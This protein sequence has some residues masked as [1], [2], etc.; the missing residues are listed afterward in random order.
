M[1]DAVRNNPRIVQIF[2]GLITLPFAFWGI[3]SYIGNPGTGAGSDLASVG[4]V[5]ITYP[6]FELAVRERQEQ[7]RQSLGDAF[8][9]DMMNSPQIRLSILN[10]MIDQQLLMLDAAN[11]RLVTSD[12]ALRSLIAGI[13]VFQ[14]NGAFSQARYE[15][16]LRAQGNSP[17]RFEARVREELSLRQLLGT[18]DDAA[19][20]SATQTEAIVRIQVEERKFNEFRIAAAPFTKNLK[21]DPEVMRKFYD[22]NISRFEVPEQV[23]AEY[24]ALSLDDLMSRVMVSDA[25]IR[26]WYDDHLD[27]Y[28]QPEERRASH[29]LIIPDEADR[30]K[31]KAQAEELLKDARQNPSRFA[32]L[33]QKHS[34]DPGSAEKG[35]DLGFFGRGMMVEPFDDAVF[36]LKKGDI[37]DVVESDFGYHIIRLTDIREAKQRPFSEVRAEIGDELKRQ[38][39]NREFAEAAEAFNNLVYEQSDSLQPAADQFG[40]KIERSG[41]IP[42]NADPSFRA[43]L[44][45]LDNDRVLAD[46]FSEDALRNKRNTEVVEVAPNTLLAAR[47]VEHFEA[48]IH[49]FEAVSNDIERILKNEQAQA[50]ARDAGEAALAELREGK[51]TVAWSATHGVSRMQTAQSSLPAVAL[52]AIFKA[53]AQKLPAYVG[54]EVDDGYMLLRI[55]AVAPPEE[56]DEN[57]LEALGAGYMRVVAQEDLAAYLSSLRSRYKVDINLSLLENRDR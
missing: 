50:Q 14:E 6:Q 49:P 28:R 29:I 11:K 4:D 19:F 16:V 15:A 20:V 13:P 31:A 47:V 12:P 46:L 37:S 41:W 54:V 30:E 7:L 48:T 24:V 3:E 35:G 36:S 39:A 42:G 55:T 32:E 57:R 9:P 33:A 40:L 21:I 25:E 51:D 8:Q 27:R 38:T 34:R 23:K 1:F 2:L 52:Q 17:A 5:K 26:S 45:V 10:G 44:G 18:I 56:V 22:D 53:N 43:T